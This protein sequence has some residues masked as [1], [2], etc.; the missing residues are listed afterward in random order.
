MKEAILQEP[1][2]DKHVPS[3]LLVED[4]EVIRTLLNSALSA[5]RYRVVLASTKQ[6]G[7]EYIGRGEFD[8]VLVDKNL[9]DGSGFDVIKPAKDRSP[10]SEAIV[11]TAYSDTESA[12]QAV[13]LGVFRYVRK[14]FDLKALLLD[15]DQ[16]L[17]KSGLRRDLARRTRELEQ[18]NQA[19][20][21]S[22]ERYRML[23]NSANDGI[24]LFPF[25]VDDEPQRFV[26]VNDVACRWLGYPREEFLKLTISDLHEAD[27]PLPSAERLTTLLQKKHILYEANLRARTGERIPVEISSRLFEMGGQ[28]FV[29]DMVRDITERKK[30]AEE[31]AQLEEQFREAQKMEA[32]GRLAGGVAHDMN[33]VLGAIMGFAAALEAEIDPRD[34]QQTD[35]AGILK[36]CCKGRDLTR[37]LLGF[38]RKGKYL[39]D[40]ISFN[41]MAMDVEKILERTIP[42][43]INIVLDFEESLDFVEGDSGQLNHAIMNVCINAV[44]AMRGKGILK[45]KTRN[46]Q[47]S[48]EDLVR[49][50]DAVPG[51]Y[52]LFE[53]SDTGVG[54]SQDVLARAFEPF[55]TTKPLGRGTG[56]GLAMVYGTVKNHDGF[57]CIESKEDSGTLVKIYLPAITYAQMKSIA[58]QRRTFP[59]KPSTIKVG[60]AFEDYTQM[61]TN[62]F[63][64]KEKSAKADNGDK[65]TILLVDDEPMI[66]NA[67]RRLLER[68]GYSVLLAEN[69]EAALKLYEEEQ[70][71]IWLVVLD[72]IMPIMDG[73]EAFS[74]LQQINPDVRV[75]LSSG[76]SK[77]E[78]ADE[79]LRQGAAGFVEKPFDLKT[80]KNELNKVQTN[81]GVEL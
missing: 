1:D 9:P 76:F 68:L 27:Q 72:L 45:L 73:E 77:E 32:V 70:E 55:F 19:L 35:I 69:G 49:Q 74:R 79:L 63:V 28:W 41:E 20:K 10:H 64:R 37:D 13:T 11:I 44:D 21:E 24:L 39:K 78:K 50:P 71:R 60:R 43:L 51:K 5:K 40:Y 7:L 4:E 6:E 47:L 80:L 26:E 42:K 57:V 56:L 38:A 48:K 22:D 16:A 30:A 46:V 23:F 8:L 3:I 29:L 34:P 33:N 31:R 67:G 2:N 52:V 75:L 62:E 65:E 58:K 36:A 12:I 66:R 54:M 15:I 18:S 25:A 61:S 17:E 59:A 81:R 53:V 14:P